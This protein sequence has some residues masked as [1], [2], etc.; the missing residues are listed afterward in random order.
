MARKIILRSEDGQLLDVG[1]V[2]I[3]ASCS[4]NTADSRHTGPVAKK[5]NGELGLSRPKRGSSVAAMILK[6]AKIEQPG[7]VWRLILHFGAFAKLCPVLA[8]GGDR[9]LR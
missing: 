5:A 1:E 6:Q 8:Q 7:Q 9:L 2:L 3:G 4:R